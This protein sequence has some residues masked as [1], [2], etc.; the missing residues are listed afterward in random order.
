[1]L[2]LAKKRLF[3]TFKSKLTGSIKSRILVSFAAAVLAA[4]CTS[5]YPLFSYMEPIGRYDN[6]LENITVANNIIALSTE[7]H[8]DARNLM[9]DLEKEE[10]RAIYNEKIQALKAS[11]QKLESG[12]AGLT[13][14]ESVSALKSFMETYLENCEQATDSGSG[15][16]TAERIEIMDYAKKVLGFIDSNIKE[17]ISSEIEYSKSIRQELERT[18]SKIITLT[19]VILFTVLGVCML[20]G[21]LMASGISGTLRRIA[22]QADRVAC[23]DLTAEKVIVR[24][25]DELKALSVSFNKMVEN[26]KE[27][28][29]KVSAGSKQVLQVSDQL[30]QSTSDSSAASEQINISIQEIADGSQSQVTLTEKTASTI[31][32]MYNMVRNISDKTG[33]AKYSSDEAQKAAS[34]GERSITEVISQMNSINSTIEQSAYILEEFINKSKEIGQIIADITSIADQTNLLSLNAAI[35]AARAGEQGKGFAVVAEEVRK[36]AEQ[37]SASA[38]KINSIIS[39]IKAQS[40][41]MAESMERSIHEIK[42]GIDI[43]NN[44]GEAFEEISSAIDRVDQQINEICSEVEFINEAIM[45]IKQVGDDIVSITRTSAAKTQDVA[46]SVEE[47]SAGIEEVFSTTNILNNLASDLQKIVNSFKL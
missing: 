46:A 17:I 31:D 45:D 37:S 10:L 30:N 40:E 18:T 19:I 16:E 34:E 28:I 14:S 38:R 36:L 21:S 42:A 22:V 25:N 15:M 3:D 1:M 24:S 11:V 39:S 35:E 44:A 7:V 8:T 29:S 32:G 2:G 27:M 43:T 33:N 20:I 12:L 41:K 4:G 5:L 26:L 9:I 23:G 6:V 13:S 47:M